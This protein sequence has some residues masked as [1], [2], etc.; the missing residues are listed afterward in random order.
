MG[1]VSGALC[2]FSDTLAE[3]R[4]E[5]LRH[6]RQP[7]SPPLEDLTPHN[8]GTSASAFSTPSTPRTSSLSCPLA[9]E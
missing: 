2:R 8:I 3:R 4:L 9:M 5:P 7:A 6:D 1:C